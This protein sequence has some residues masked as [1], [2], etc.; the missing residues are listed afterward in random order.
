M[1]AT[2]TS[3]DYRLYELANSSPGKPG[4]LRVSNGERGSSI[5]V[6]LWDVP[7]GNFGSFTAEVP[8]PLGI[9]SLSLLD[10]RTVKGFIC[11]PFGLAGAQDITAFGGWAAYLASL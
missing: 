11:E 6:E 3:G 8:P 10:G 4:L 7:V 2:S 1:E 9:G 5:A